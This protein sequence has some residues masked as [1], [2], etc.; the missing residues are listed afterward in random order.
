[1]LV[2]NK[3]VS[4]A[5][6]DGVAQVTRITRSATTFSATCNSEG[7]TRNDVRFTTPDAVGASVPTEP[8]PLCVVSAA[9]V[10]VHGSLDGT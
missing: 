5:P 10:D 7:G 1:V 9:P 4:D 2:S 3:I 8:M 6:A